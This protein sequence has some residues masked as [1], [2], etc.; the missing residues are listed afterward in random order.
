MWKN[1]NM[2]HIKIILEVY[3]LIFFIFDS[4]KHRAVMHLFDAI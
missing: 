1:C 3:M 4:V 2:G